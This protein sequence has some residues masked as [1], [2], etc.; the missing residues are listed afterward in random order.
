MDKRFTAGP[1]RG[2]AP[3]GRTLLSCEPGM[4]VGVS[5]SASNRHASKSKKRRTDEGQ[6]AGSH[7]GYQN[8]VQML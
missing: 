1:S 4:S 7:V 5:K 8:L 6:C 2:A 3:S